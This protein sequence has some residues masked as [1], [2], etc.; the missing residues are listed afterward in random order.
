MK[1][2]KYSVKYVSKVLRHIYLNF[3]FF[4]LKKSIIN[5]TCKSMYLCFS[6]QLVVCILISNLKKHSKLCQEESISRQKVYCTIQQFMLLYTREG[7]GNLLQYSC[8][9]TPMDRG[10]WQAA[11]HGVTKSLTRLSDFTFAFH[12]HALEKE[13]ATHS[14]ILF[15][16][17]FE[18]QLFSFFF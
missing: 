9:E 5:S 15:F 13:M 2:D 7:N 12:F 16:F 11:V 17:F 18:M 4:T 8:L 10:A 14:S 1:T 6:K 3:F